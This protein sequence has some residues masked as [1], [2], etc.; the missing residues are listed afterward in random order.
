[1]TQPERSTHLYE[2]Y[3]PPADVSHI[4]RKWLDIP[5]ASLS[6][7]Q[8]LDI[9]LP[10]EGDGPFPVIVYL[11]GGAFSIGDKRSYNFV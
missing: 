11:H 4:R 2:D 9:Y 8:N 6:P 10:D 1:M 3:I 7:S 5:Y